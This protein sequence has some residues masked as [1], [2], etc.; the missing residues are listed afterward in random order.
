MRRALAPAT[1]HS[2]ELLM[3]RRM[4][5]NQRGWAWAHTKDAESKSNQPQPVLLDGEQDAHDAAV[6]EQQRVAEDVAAAFGIE[7]GG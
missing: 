6:E 4:E 5:L 1:A 3:L 2:D 7:T